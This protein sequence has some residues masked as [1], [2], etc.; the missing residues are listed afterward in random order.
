LPATQGLFD[1]NRVERTSGRASGA[2]AVAVNEVSGREVS[3]GN[4]PAPPGQTWGGGGASSS[5]VNVVSSSNSEANSLSVSSS[6]TEWSRQQKRGYHRV[7]SV[8]QYWTANGFQVLWVCLTT[9]VDSDAQAL[10]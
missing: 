10:A 5:L 4:L 9:G 7:W 8:L 1:L 2:L 6:N 3:G